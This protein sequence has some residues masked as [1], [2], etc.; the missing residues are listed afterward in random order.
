MKIFYNDEYVAPDHSFDTTRKAA[1][2][3]DAIHE[4][5]VPGVEL[6]DPV[7][8]CPCRRGRPIRIVD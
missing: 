7:W 3:A 4:T 8:I 6:V 5:G 1:W 2:I